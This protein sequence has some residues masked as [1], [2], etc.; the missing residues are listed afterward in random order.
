M[1]SFTLYFDFTNK[2]VL[3]VWEVSKTINETEITIVCLIFNMPSYLYTLH[4]E[5][6]H[7]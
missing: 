5:N 6:G 4:K 7:F 1:L 2:F 3:Q